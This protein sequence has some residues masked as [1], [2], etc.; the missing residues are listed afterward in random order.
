MTNKEA[1]EILKS[2]RKRLTDSVSNQLDKDIEAF[3]IAI[4]N[5][6]NQK[7][8]I[9]ELRNVRNEIQDRADN[10]PY[11]NQLSIDAHKLDIDIINKHINK[12]KGEKQ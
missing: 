1:I 8:I 9:E 11:T 2:Y 4:K 6:E 5:L 3:E 12:L 7:S 10:I